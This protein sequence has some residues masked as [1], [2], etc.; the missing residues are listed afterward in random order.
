MP[1]SLIPLLFLVI[2]VAEISAFVLVGN[3]IG[4]LPTIA[5]VFLTAIAGSVLLR[6]QG[7]AAMTRIQAELA[8]GRIP[9][10]ELVNGVMI[11]LAGILLM[12]PGFVTDLLGLLLFVPPIRDLVWRFLSERVTFQTFGSR[13]FGENFGGEGADNTNAAPD[14]VDLDEDEYRRNPDRKSP[15]SIDDG[16]NQTRH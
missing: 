1:F 12:T 10:R 16:S 7:F 14:I 2:P 6:W 3:Q 9:G 15:W 8:A 5:L 4:V 13:R 11:L